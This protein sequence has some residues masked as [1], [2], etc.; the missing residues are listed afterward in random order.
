[1]DKEQ[2]AIERIKLASEMSIH[3]YG[4]PLVCTYSG[5]KDSDVILELFKRSGVS[6]EV[7]N[8]YTTA[9]APQTVRHI[10]NVFKQLKLDGIKCGI[11]MPVYG[12][13]PTSMWKLIPQKL[14]PP[15]RKARYCCSVLKET[16]CANRYIATGVRW[17]EST[18]RSERGEFEKIGHTKK[19]KEKFSTVML[20]NDNVSYRRMTELC[21][22]QNKMVVNPIIDWTHSDVWEFIHSGH[23]ETC[24]L[25][26]CGYNRVGCIGCPIAGKKRWKEFSDFPKYK[27]IYIHAF[28]RMLEE[29]DKRG[30][31]N[32]WK[33][34][35]EVFLWWMEDDNI[36]GQMS[37]EDFIGEER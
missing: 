21:M 10:R 14:M 25:Y 1:M 5:G 23:I 17:D 9:D 8:S 28:E 30:K 16:G 20:M 26:Q 32:R 29:R 33:S 36:P 11:E 35:E 37:I 31:E 19:E 15:T 22:K 24:E 3:H 27:Q 34:G 12:G 18:A 6:F 2:K 7:H 4:K 13:K